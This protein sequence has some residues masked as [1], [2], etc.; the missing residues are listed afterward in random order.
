MTEFDFIAKIAGG[1]DVSCEGLIC[2][3]GDDCAVIDCGSK[4]L[5][6]TTDALI[7]GVHFNL[8]WT[9][10]PTLGRKALSVNLSDI[11]AMGGIP[12]YFLIS[13]AIPKS[14]SVES[15]VELYAGI[16][17]V[18]R[19]F[20]VQLVGGDTTASEAGIAISI[21]AIGEAGKLGAVYR[22]GARAGDAVYVTGSLGGSALGFELLRRGSKG[23]MPAIE[24]HLNPSPRV[25]EGQLLGALGFVSSMIDVSD[26]L[27]ADLG[28]V[29]R[30]SSVG[31]ELNAELIPMMDDFADC[32]SGEGF[33]S[34]ELALSGG[35]DYELA[36]TVPEARIAEF[37]SI[38]KL[39]CGWTR[40]GKI[41]SDIGARRVLSA[42]GKILAYDKSGFDHFDF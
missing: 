7:E 33:D 22:S 16:N 5:L 31:F 20:G 15:M 11:A 36:F 4:R 38:C 21:T 42:D 8:A 26:G 41:V 30:S 23:L 6:I 39:D 29:A 17:S 3:I 40:I 24:R 35:E 28:H 19:E 10:L 32:A 27:L 9:D 1:G 14:R 2:G 25:R 13:L 34:L 12:K 37:E 18:A